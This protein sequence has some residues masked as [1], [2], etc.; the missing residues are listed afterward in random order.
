MPC[1]Q[2]LNALLLLYHWLTIVFAKS[3]H[4]VF[5]FMLAGICSSRRKRDTGTQDYDLKNVP[6]SLTPG[7]RGNAHI[8]GFSV[9]QRFAYDNCCCI[10]NTSISYFYQIDTYECIGKP[11]RR[12]LF[13]ENEIVP[14]DGY[15]YHTPARVVSGMYA[16]T[17]FNHTRQCNFISYVIFDGVGC[18]LVHLDWNSTILYH[19]IPYNTI[20][21]EELFYNKAY[22]PFRV[23]CIDRVLNTPDA[24]G[25]HEW[26]RHYRD[27]ILYKQRSLIYSTDIKIICWYVMD[28]GVSMEAADDPFDVRLSLRDHTA[29]LT[30]T[31]TCTPSLTHSFLT[32]CSILPGQHIHYRWFNS[33]V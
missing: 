12:V 28:I 31:Y 9:L 11:S 22:Q 30:S 15:D 25:I 29:F 18:N 2:R 14:M 6:S 20:L 27:D 16:H 26:T 5:I 32:Y 1:L 21:I 33:S 13:K 17:T 7:S 24:K 10:S 8:Q 23:I 4:V 3:H 19:T